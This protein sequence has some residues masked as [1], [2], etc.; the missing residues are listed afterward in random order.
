MEKT[1]TINDLVRLLYSETSEAERFELAA[2]LSDNY[3]FNEKHQELAISK[4]A[5]PKVSFLPSKQ[6]LNAILAY[7]ASTSNEV[8]A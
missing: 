3:I 1:F 5:L 6:S 4:A 2:V 8:L 7:S